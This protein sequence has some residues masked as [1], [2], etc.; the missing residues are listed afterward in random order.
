MRTRR[1]GLTIAAGLATAAALAAAPLAAPAK[2]TVK[3]KGPSYSKVF[4]V[5]TC[6]NTG[7]T[8]IALTGKAPSLKLRVVGRNKTGTLTISGLADL[9]GKLTSVAVGDD[10]SIKVK[11]AFTAGG[12][13]GPFTVTGFCA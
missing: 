8:D 12:V 1:L 5:V 11:G 13:K 3:V 9:K 6:K 10:S 7:E 4:T 2:T